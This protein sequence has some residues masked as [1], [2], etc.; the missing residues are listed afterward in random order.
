[1]STIILNAEKENGKVNSFARDLSISEYFENSLLLPLNFLVPLTDDL[2]NFIGQENI[3]AEIPIIGQLFQKNETV[4]DSTV[5]LIT[6]NPDYETEEIS[7][8]V[9]K[10]LYEVLSEMNGSV[11]VGE[12]TNQ[13]VGDVITVKISD[14][15]FKINTHET[16]TNFYKEETLLAHDKSKY[17]F[18]VII[19]EKYFT[20]DDT[21]NIR[22]FIDT[23]I[24]LNGEVTVSSVEE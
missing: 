2:G 24:Y 17:N 1:M 13:E 14:Y 16:F 21:Y 4:V 20:D 18:D 5:I 6:D 22:S 15:E 3:N 9:P 19:D 23:G 7:L 10:S 8:R 12:T 11:G